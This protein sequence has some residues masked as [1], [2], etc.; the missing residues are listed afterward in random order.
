MKSYTGINLTM[1]KGTI[2]GGSLKH[3]FISKSSTEAELIN[4]SDG[5]NQSL[6]TKF[7][8]ECKGYVVNSSTIYQDNKASILVEWNGKRSSKKGTRFIHIRYF[9]ITDKVQNGEVDNKYMPTGEM[10][11]DIFSSQ[12]RCKANYSER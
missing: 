8:F 5:I 4:V 1:G 9:F 7:F 10:I 3:K 2:Y 11:A 6:W 12:N